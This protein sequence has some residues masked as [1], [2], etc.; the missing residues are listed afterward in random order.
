MAHSS[1]SLHIPQ[2]EG[3]RVN[4]NTDT[5]DRT[6]TQVDI[7][8]DQSVLGTMPLVGDT[9][10]SLWLKLQYP[11]SVSLSFVMLPTSSSESLE[12]M[13]SSDLVIIA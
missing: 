13:R 8:V 2:R 9:K 10:K 6:P 12:M 11:G 5:E 3:I 7:L 1:R 4:D